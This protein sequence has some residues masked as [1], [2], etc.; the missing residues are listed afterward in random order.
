MFVVRG[1]SGKV[2]GRYATKAEAERRVEQLRAGA[3]R[4]APF[5]FGGGRSARGRSAHSSHSPMHSL[6]QAN[7]LEH[8]WAVWTRTTP[9]QP[10]RFHTVYLTREEAQKASQALSYLH[11]VR[12][13]H[14]GYGDA[15]KSAR[16][17][18]RRGRR[19]RSALSNILKDARYDERH[20][21]RGWNI[22]PTVLQEPRLFPHVFPELTRTDHARLAALY[23][24]RAN[25]VQG[26]H[27]KWIVRGEKIYGRNGPS[28]S[29]GFHAD[30][31]ESVKETVRR[32]AHGYSKL[33]DA[34]RAHLAASRMRGIQ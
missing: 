31:P 18:V 3:A 9:S 11:D 12:I 5:K 13:T 21:F 15:P 33:R 24:T 17:P 34:A 29:G 20:R 16:S 19:A 32:L 8:A 26:Q 14:E 23:D 27:L 6:A 4:L 28:I 2:V 10:W 7:F 22:Q 1:K 30:W 25:L